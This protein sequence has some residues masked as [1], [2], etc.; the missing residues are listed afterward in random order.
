MVKKSTAQDTPLR[1]PGA[2]R[3][4]AQREHRD[5]WWDS[6][7][8]GRTYSAQSPVDIHH[9]LPLAVEACPLLVYVLCRAPLEAQCLNAELAAMRMAREHHVY[10]RLAYNLPIPQRGI[11]CQQNGWLIVGH[12]M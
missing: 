10:G 1:H 11:V 7:P 2:R 3:W 9:L 4:G 5:L 8:D 12:A 6:N